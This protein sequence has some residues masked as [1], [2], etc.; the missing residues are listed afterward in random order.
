MATLKIWETVRSTY[1]LPLLQLDDRTT[2]QTVTFTGTAAQSA[3]FDTD[4]SV[5]SIQ[6]DAACAI[7]VGENPTALA[8]DYPLAANTV[9]DLAVKPGLRI[10][11]ITTA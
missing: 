6:S 3:A 10:S 11:A 2:Y 8:T 7:R 4:T 9:L 5:I 1:G